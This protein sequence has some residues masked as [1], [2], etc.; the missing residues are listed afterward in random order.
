MKFYTIQHIN[1]WEYAKKRGYLQGNK[2]FAIGDFK[3]SYSWMMEQMKKRLPKYNGEYP[4]WVW[5]KKPDGEDVEEAYLSKGT[6]GILLEIQLDRK[7]VLL[8]DFEA[9][10]IVLMNTFFSLSEKED[11]LYE[12]GKINITKEESWERIFD[13]HLLSRQGDWCKISELQG[14]TGRININKIKV[15][16]EFVA[17]GYQ[18]EDD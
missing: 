13:L 7:D 10:H 11:K 3:K 2:N 12:E 16:Y 5:T 17:T 4:I 9:W 8:S 6:K 1:A 18:M 15:L 14:V